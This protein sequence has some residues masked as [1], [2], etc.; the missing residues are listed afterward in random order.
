VTPTRVSLRTRVG[1]AM[2]LVALGALVLSY[3]ATY[4]LVRRSLQHNALTNLERRAEALRDISAD[5]NVARL[6]RQRRKLALQLTDIQ[7]VQ[8]RRDGS[9]AEPDL[10]G[11]VL[12]APLEASDLDGARLLSG[13]QVSGR[14]GS[15]VFLA[16][17]T[18]AGTRLGGRT[19]VIATDDVDMSVLRKL[20]PLLLFAGCVVLGLAFLV[21]AWFARRLTR[22]IAA[23]ERTAHQLA[24][25]DLSAR[26]HLPP[27]TDDELAALARTL[28][29]MAVQLEHARG[30]ERA[31]LLSISH[32]LRTPLTSIRG[33]AEALADGTLDGADPDQRNR[34]ASVIGA[35]ARRLERLVRDLLDL[36]RLDSRQF[37]LNVR[38]C[39]VGAVVRDAA[40]AF[41]PQAQELG[42]RLIVRSATPVPADV[43]ADRVAQIVANLVENAL[44]YAVATVEVEVA[45]P[46]DDGND[47]VQIVVVDDGPGIRS[48][49][50]AL[51]FERLYT[52]RSTPG[53]AVGTG[54]GLAI[55]RE[56]AGAMHGQ[57]WAEPTSD[58][59]TRFVVS[60]PTN[61]TMAVPEGAPR[62]GGA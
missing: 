2:V 19:V 51:V 17:P 62:S 52:V 25:G 53:R 45:A 28:D 36:S 54:L 39:D 42:V 35:E 48:E 27:S 15:T 24:A 1:V 8:I 56:L 43:D 14:R 4:G 40:E 32:D 47:H 58:R 38:P 59:G 55:V 41:V 7:V 60:L 23:I 3:V 21:A 37:S 34:A 10:A 61:V 49:E 44:K 9:L 11:S 16:V 30:S 50:L 20:F 5:P 12:P 46:A 22:P 31:F 33:Y 18:Q 13:E 26:T 6:P 57:A 29:N